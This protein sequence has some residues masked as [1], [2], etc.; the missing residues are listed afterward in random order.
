MSPRDTHPEPHAL[1]RLVAPIRSTAI[2]LITTPIAGLALSPLFPAS[3]G[4]MVHVAAVLPTILL[5]IRLHLLTRERRR[6]IQQFRT[7]HARLCTDC[8]AP[9]PPNSTHC[10]ECNLQITPD[11]AA[12]AWTHR[13]PANE[14]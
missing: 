11:Q 12:A 8:T 4:P 14:P 6:I 9:L 2:A 1:R 13:S 10:P 3:A 7:H 5:A